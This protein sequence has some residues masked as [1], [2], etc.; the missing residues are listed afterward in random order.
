[1]STH[2]AK[3]CFSLAFHVSP[4]NDFELGKKM[5]FSIKQGADAKMFFHTIPP[6][7]RAT[8]LHRSTIQTVLESEAYYYQRK[9]DNQVFYIRKEDPILIAKINGEDFFSLEEIGKKFGISSTK[10]MNQVRNKKF[11][12]KIDW[13]SDE[14]FPERVK[15][16]KEIEEIGVN[17]LFEKLE[18]AHTKLA[19]LSI[20]VKSLEEIQE[21]N[22]QSSTGSD[23]LLQAKKLEKEDKKIHQQLHNNHK[24]TPT[25]LK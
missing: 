22:A 17:A 10:F 18:N 15:E 14:L 21:R 2:W 7:E 5:R 13:I 3:P 1:M 11:P 19:K 9:K 24:Q 20:R 25:K 23:V 8:G 12:E 16:A 4:Y 6:A